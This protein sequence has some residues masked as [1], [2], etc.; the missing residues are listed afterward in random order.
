[1]Q[2]AC[3]HFT[4]CVQKETHM[5]EELWPSEDSDVI[6]TIIGS[7]V[8]MAM[9]SQKKSYE[10]NTKLHLCPYSNSLFSLFYGNLF[11]RYQIQQ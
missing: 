8:S 7:I 4:I 2:A 10:V 11:S 9:L 6:D 5:E 1:M 3:N